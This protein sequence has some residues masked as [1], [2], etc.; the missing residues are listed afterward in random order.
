[1][2]LP[3]PPVGSWRSS[4]GPWATLPSMPSPRALGSVS[5]ASRA[6][7]LFNRGRSGF[8]DHLT[9]DAARQL[10]GNALRIDFTSFSTNLVARLRQGKPACGE[11]ARA[12]PEWPSLAC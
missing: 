12:C 6:G 3:A 11:G 10:W 8:P 5:L 9:P 4:P 2:D 7:A 1:V